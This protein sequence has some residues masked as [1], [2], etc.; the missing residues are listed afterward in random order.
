MKFNKDKL[1]LLYIK[2][3]YILFPTKCDCCNKICHRFTKMYHVNRWG[4]NKRIVAH[5]YCLNCMHSAQDVLNEIDS[6]EIP[7]GIAG[8]DDFWHYSKKDNTRMDIRMQKLIE[9]KQK[10][11]KQKKAK[12]SKKSKK[13]KNSSQ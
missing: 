6:D 5:Y 12:K 10:N 3:Q 4:P 1:R 8:I 7:F 11:K 2:K 9:S 13:S